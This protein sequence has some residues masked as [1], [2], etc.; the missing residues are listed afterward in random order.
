MAGYST[1]QSTQEYGLYV[2]L[3]ASGLVKTGPGNLQ[4]VVINSHS[5]GTLK[6]WDN[7]AGSGTIIFNTITLGASER[8][9]PLYGAKFLTGAYLTIGGTADV[10]VI[11]N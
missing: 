2:N 3:S 6:F 4:G 9:I 10:T 7:T 8:F 11:Y 1:L 5:S